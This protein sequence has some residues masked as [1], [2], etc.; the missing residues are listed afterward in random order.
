VVAGTSGLTD[1][2]IYIVAT[3]PTVT[4]FTLTGYSGTGTF[5]WAKCHTD[6][7]ASGGG[8]V[9]PATTKHSFTYE[10]SLGAWL[11]SDGGKVNGAFQVT[12]TS[13]FDGDLDIDAAVVHD[14]TFTH[15][16][17]FKTTA[18]T[19]AAANYFLKSADAA[20]TSSWVAFGIY[21]SSGTRLGP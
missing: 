16:G 21:D 12:G 20:G 8:L 6:A 3:V 17:A 4:T 19:T 7:Q 9:I 13:D 11:V 5:D 18:D 14:G 1:E 2:G 10:S 15:A